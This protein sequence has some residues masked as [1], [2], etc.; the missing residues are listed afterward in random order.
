ME[1]LEMR[2]KVMIMIAVMTAMFF[3]ALNMTI[4]GTS[5]PK[6]V[7]EIGGMD[8]FNWVFTIYAL[9][10]SITAALV[11]KLS[12]IYGRKIF[13]LMGIG[14][15]MVGGLLSGFSTS[16]I[17]L[18][19][20]RGIQGFGGGMVMSTAFTTVGDLFSPRERGR[21]QGMMGGVFGLSSLF[22]PTL[23]G[24][25][26][27]NLDW[28]W[29]FW[30][31]LPIGF[32]AFFMIWKMYPHTEK[33][34]NEKIDYFGAMVLSVVIF[35]LMLGFSLVGKDFAW[36]SPEIIGLFSISITSLILFILIE[37]RVSSPIIPLDLF[38]NRVVAISNIVSFLLGMGMF[39]T[40]MYVPFY[41]QGVLG[42]SATTAGLVEMVMT[43]SMV[44]CSAIAGQFI[45]KTG[46]YKALGL[47][48]IAVMAIGIFLNSTL[49]VGA[50]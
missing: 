12:D 28:S 2:K 5:L 13:I 45:T 50:S 48:G 31:F 49:T 6:I 20:Y 44:A 7:A 37:S 42:R 34:E 27:D 26:V 43:I 15:F 35:T 24:Y 3:S 46:K 39:G 16:I 38:K 9:V 8:Y 40:I 18:I 21:W 36:N 14:I 47:V 32:F 22:G 33:R 1:E 25:I 10:S 29:V 17:E 11:G 30:V 23:G 41:V 19:V 4:V